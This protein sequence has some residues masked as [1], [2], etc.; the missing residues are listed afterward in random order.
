M[1]TRTGSELLD[2]TP[3]APL[4]VDLVALPARV[5]MFVP[6]VEDVPWQV[7]VEHALAIQTGVWGG[8]GNIVVPLALADDEIFWW[9]VDLH[10]PDV[11]ALHTP[12]Y[13]DARLIAPGRYEQATERFRAGW[14]GQ[15]FDEKTIAEQI[16]RI[17]SDAFWWF[18]LPR[19]ISELLID[20]VTPLHHE[21]EINFTTLSVN[22]VVRST[23][24]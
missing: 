1:P 6:D 24:T 13:E 18:E 20:R 9:L 5:C 21:R 7:M 19:R 14:A 23:A 3:A 8:L 11:I 12:T 10:D 2:L 15:G 22:A 16:E 4:S 17:G